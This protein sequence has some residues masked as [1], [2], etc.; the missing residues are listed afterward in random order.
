MAAA[1]F[2]LALAVPTAGNADPTDAFTPQTDFPFRDSSLDAG[3]RLNDLLGRLT[4]DE[5][6]S[7]ATAGSNSNNPVPRLGLNP[8]RS[9]GGEALHGVK[10]A[11]AAQRDTVFPSSIGLSQTWDEDLLYKVGDIIGNE[12]LAE[13]GNAGRL[14][15]VVDLLRDPRYGRA[16]ETL[17]EDQNLTG[18]LGNAISAGMNQ[19]TDQGYIQSVPILKHFF[20]YGTEINRLW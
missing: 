6:I 2:V 10:I 20:A 12:T 3:T 18:V 5:K 14:A 9:V 13:N 15:P 1:A 17:G 7:I 16:Y 19:R 8:G 4:L 11:Q